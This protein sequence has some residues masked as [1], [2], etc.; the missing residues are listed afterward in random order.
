[1]HNYELVRLL[2]KK[3]NHAQDL[4]AQFGKGSAVGAEEVGREARRN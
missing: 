3:K 4:C 1:M 2:T